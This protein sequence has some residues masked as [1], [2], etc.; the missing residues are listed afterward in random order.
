MSWEEQ[1]KRDISWLHGWI[2]AR[3][4]L[5]TQGSSTDEV[6]YLQIV[7]RQSSD[8]LIRLGILCLPQCTRGL[9]MVN[10][11]YLSVSYIRMGMIRYSHFIFQNGYQEVSGSVQLS[12]RLRETELRSIMVAN[13]VT[14]VEIQKHYI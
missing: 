12:E 3:A 10:C 13:I 7:F 1:Q 8:N 5:M 6:I 4:N 2:S 9:I 11:L 14:G